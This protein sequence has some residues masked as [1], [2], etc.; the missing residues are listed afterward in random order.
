MLFKYTLCWLITAI[1]LF[2]FHESIG[3]KFKDTLHSGYSEQVGEAKPFTISEYSIYSMS[4]S[5]V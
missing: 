5:C 2:N 1:F 3:G 4:I